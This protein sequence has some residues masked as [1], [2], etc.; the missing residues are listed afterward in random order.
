MT[1]T[2]GQP[3][4]MQ[5]FREWE[6]MEN[7]PTGR[8]TTREFSL[9][10]LTQ[11]GAQSLSWSSKAREIRKKQVAQEVNFPDFADEH[12]L[13]LKKHQRLSRVCSRQISTIQSQY[14]KLSKEIR[15]REAAA[16]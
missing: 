10:S 16:R 11:Y 13:V 5:H 1:T 4:Y 9:C 3:L 12:D 7:I 14:A 15:I 6:K 2:Y 8:N